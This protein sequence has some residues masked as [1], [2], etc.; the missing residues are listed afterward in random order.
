MAQVCNLVWTTPTTS[1]QVFLNQE[2][3]F[4]SSYDAGAWVLDTGATNHMTGCR[5]ALST[6]DESVR[7]AVCF[8]DGLKVEI[9]GIGA[10]TITGKS[11]DHQVLTEVYYI[12]ALKCN[13]VSLGQLED[14][15]CRVEIDNGAM[16]VFEH[17]QTQCQ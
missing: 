6:L 17:R 4:P 12:P 7:G 10:V 5:E 11:H 1:Q 16:E 14:G 15:G 2:R 8:G 9:R 13:I 3:V